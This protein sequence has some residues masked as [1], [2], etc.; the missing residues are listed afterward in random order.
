MKAARGKQRV[1]YKGT[2]L[3]LSTDFSAETL[4][5]RR[6]WHDICKVLKE[7]TLQPKILYPARLS[8]RIGEEIKSFPDKQKSKRGHHH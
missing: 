4:Q 8:F 7:K 3:M 2:P 5:A 1:T 6:E